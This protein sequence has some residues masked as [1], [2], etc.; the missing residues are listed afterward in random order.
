M[1]LVVVRHLKQLRMCASC[2]DIGERIVFGVG[3]FQRVSR[4]EVS[5]LAVLDIHA[6]HAVGRRGHDER[7]VETYVARG[8]ADFAV[9]VDLAIA[10]ADVPFA[11]YGG[12]I[13]GALQNLGQ[14]GF[15]RTNDHWRITGEDFRAGIPPRIASRHQAIARRRAGG[16]RRIAVG[17]SDSFAGHAV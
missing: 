17:E 9:P 10:E 15:A 7:L 6:G 8:R 13:S 14:G 1:L 5:H 2:R 11:D 4:F 16:G 12:V 3:D